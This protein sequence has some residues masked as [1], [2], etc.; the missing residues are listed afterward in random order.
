MTTVKC[1]LVSHRKCLD[2]L[3]IRCGRKR[4]PRKLP[5][6]GVEL[7]QH[8]SETYA[9]VPFIICKC[10]DE[11]DLRGRHV[12]GIYRVSGVKS[13]VDRLALAFENGFDLVDLSEVH[14]NVIANVLKVYL[15][16]L[17]EPLLTFRLYPDFLE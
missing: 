14:P 16:T 9:M 17:P 13:K 5:I 8:L 15:R 11:I 3:S 4:L 12:K 10:V 7:G 6:F 2:S 1:G